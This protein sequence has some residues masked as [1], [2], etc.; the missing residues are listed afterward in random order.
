MIDLDKLAAQSLVEH[1]GELIFSKER[2]AYLIV[3][4][5]LVIAQEF[6]YPKLSGPGTI[7]ANRIHARFEQ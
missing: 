3:R 7:I 6:D 4:E 1:E 5:C 2:Y